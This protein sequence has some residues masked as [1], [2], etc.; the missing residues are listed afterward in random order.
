MRLV[1]TDSC[2]NVETY[3]G[4]YC[5]SISR[6]TPLFNST[7]LEL[8]GLTDRNLQPIRPIYPRSKNSIAFASQIFRFIFCSL[9]LL[10]FGL[11]FF[12]GT[13]NMNQILDLCVR[14][15]RVYFF[16]IHIT[17]CNCMDFHPLH[18]YA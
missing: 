7:L 15:H 8:L 13:W 10:I 16:C 9:F 2:D 11:K 12:S 18:I 6:F 1:M 17:P 3:D 4:A 5:S 14:K